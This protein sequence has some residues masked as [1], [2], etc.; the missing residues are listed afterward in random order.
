MITMI[1]I[2]QHAIYIYEMHVIYM[3]IYTYTYVYIHIYMHIYIYTCIYIY[4][5]MYLWLPLNQTTNDQVLPYFWGK[6]PIGGSQSPTSSTRTAGSIGSAGKQEG[7]W[8]CHR[9]NSP[10]CRSTCICWVGSLHSLSQWVSSSIA[11]LRQVM[12]PRTELAPEDLSRS[13]Q[14]ERMVNKK[15]P[16]SVYL[17]LIIQNSD[18][19]GNSWEFHGT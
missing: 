10:W 16:W 6:T 3:H 4:S 1:Y 2:C 14:L 15:V 7:L 5:D 11:P 13:I 19:M 18:L 8:L 9:K 17:D 12:L